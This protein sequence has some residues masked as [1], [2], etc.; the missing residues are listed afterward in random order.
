MKDNE[1]N[2][3]KSQDS[4]RDT[5]RAQQPRERS[6]IGFPY[7]SLKVAEDVATAVHNRCGRG[8]CGI[9]ELAAQM[10]L[11]VSGT[12]RQKTA[13][14]RIFDLVEKVGRDTFSLSAIGQ[15]VVEDETRNE[16]RVEA[17]L[18][19][20]LYKEIFDKYRG[21]SLP[22][23]QALE[24]EMKELGVSHKQT[25]KARQAFESSALHAGFFD[26]GRDRLVK[27]RIEVP[28]PQAFSD[29]S[30][31]GDSRAENGSSAATID[32]IIQ[33]LMA[34]LP[35]SGEV[36]PTEQRQIWLKLLEG[37]FQLIYRDEQ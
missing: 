5:V 15:K 25:D 3:S 37:S 32:P 36:W 11:H 19:V 13:G 4:P 18:S 14:A 33:G 34:R 20:P 31:D 16:G 24:R 23:T 2:R 9:D 30:G 12:F 22:P 7:V 27:P 26:T 8:S 17:F 1:G 6:S 29:D 10:G 21:H 35:N 28:A